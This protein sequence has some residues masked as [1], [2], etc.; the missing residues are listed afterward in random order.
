MKA[1]YLFLNIILVFPKFLN[2][3]FLLKFR[4]LVNDDDAKL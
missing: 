2:R 1:A 3:D 4:L